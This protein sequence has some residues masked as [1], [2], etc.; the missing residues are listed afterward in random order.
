M[1][2]KLGIIKKYILGIGIPIIFIL[3]VWWAKDDPDI[4][5]LGDGT[6]QGFTPQEDEKMEDVHLDRLCLIILFGFLL[7]FIIPFPII[8]LLWIIIFVCA[9]LFSWPFTFKEIEFAGYVVVL[10][11]F[12]GGATALGILGE[13]VN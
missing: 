13:I 11:L 6:K 9:A 2:A 1:E 12:F 5:R 4:V 8:L 7:M 3:T 10:L